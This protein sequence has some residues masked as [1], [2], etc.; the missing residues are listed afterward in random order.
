MTVP[1][2]W[3]FICNFVLKCKPDFALSKKPFDHV[4]VG[5]KFC[6]RCQRN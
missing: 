4:D 1:C 5:V 6:L 2:G 3:T